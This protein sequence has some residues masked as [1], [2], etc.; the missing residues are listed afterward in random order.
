[1][2]LLPENKVAE[3]KYMV[4]MGWLVEGTAGNVGKHQLTAKGQAEYARLLDALDAKH[5]TL[6]KLTVLLNAFTDVNTLI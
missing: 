3:I 1:M 5:K 4:Q 6:I 2:A